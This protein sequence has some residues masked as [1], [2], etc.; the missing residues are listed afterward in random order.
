MNF[1]PLGEFEPADRYRSVSSKSSELHSM[2]QTVELKTSALL[3]PPYHMRT[4]VQR[5]YVLSV[6]RG[7]GLRQYTDLAVHCLPPRPAD[8]V[9]AWTSHPAAILAPTAI[10]LRVLCLLLL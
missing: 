4:Q 2:Q 9:S 6:S 10:A 5:H 1:L 8:E 3:A 7:P